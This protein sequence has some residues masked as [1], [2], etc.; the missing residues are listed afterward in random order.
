M[1]MVTVRSNTTG[2]RQQ[3]RNTA[4]HNIFRG[5]NLSWLRRQFKRHRSGAGKRMRFRI[6]LLEKLEFN[7]RPS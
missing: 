6:K 1:H 5:Q 2:T 3:R 4:P 7:P